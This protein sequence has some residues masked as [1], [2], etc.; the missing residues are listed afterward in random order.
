VPLAGA[1]ALW[2]AAQIWH[3]QELGLAMVA[4][5]VP[6]GLLAAFRARLRDLSTLLWGTAL[7][8]SLAAPALVAGGTLA[9]LAWTLGAAVLAG[10]GAELGERRLIAAA[11]TPL[12][13]AL[14]WTLILLAPVRDLLMAGGSPGEGVWAVALCAGALL[15]AGFALGRLGDE[16]EDGFDR[17]VEQ[18]V[19]GRDRLWVLAGGLG[20]YGLSLAALALVTALGSA[21]AD[22]EFQR[23]HTAVSTLWGVVALALVLA[24]LRRGARSARVAG[25]VLLTVT[26]AKIFL[27]DLARL[28]SVTRALSF[29]AVG[30][31]LLL[32][33]FFTQ[34]LSISER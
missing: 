9:V 1:L 31:V 5:A 22:T 33:G 4:I 12:G 13:I 17:L 26:L 34:R 29:L 32:A 2:A 21:G 3:D 15:A 16:P 23:G 6:L 11:C 24:G 19:A 18:A 25:L 10:L 7:A 14:G 27:F 30:A 28:D 8:V 20:L